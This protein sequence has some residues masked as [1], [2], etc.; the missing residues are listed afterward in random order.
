M[1]SVASSEP[2]TKPAVP[3]RRMRWIAAASLLLLVPGTI[4]ATGWRDLREIRR[5]T[6][7]RPVDVPAGGSGVYGGTRVQ[8]IGMNYIALEPGLPADRTFLRARVGITAQQPN[9]PWLDCR[10]AVVNS[11]GHTWAA[12]E[13]PPDLV[14]RTLT[15]PGEP[16]GTI[17]GGMAVPEARPGQQVFVDSY[18]LVPRPAIPSLR[19]TLSTMEDRP[20]YLRLTSSNPIASKAP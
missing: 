1:N 14:Q 2:D 6:E 9:T 12:V 7:M 3:E 16:E 15:Q 19:V 4:A 5:N 18:Y 11:A 17:C 10:L 8:L 20:A 13:Q